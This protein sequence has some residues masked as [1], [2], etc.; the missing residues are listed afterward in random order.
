MEKLSDKKIWQLKKSALNKIAGWSEWRI[1]KLIAR[2]TKWSEKKILNQAL[3]EITWTETNEKI[4]DYHIFLAVECLAPWFWKR[5][6]DTIKQIPWVAEILPSNLRDNSLKLVYPNIVQN[7]NLFLENDDIGDNEINK[8]FQA[9]I[10]PFQQ[11]SEDLKQKNEELVKLNKTRT[12]NTLKTFLNKTRMK[13]DD[14]I[15]YISYNLN[16]LWLNTEWGIR[17]IANEYWYSSEQIDTIIQNFNEFKKEVEVK[18]NRRENLSSCIIFDH[19]LAGIAKKDFLVNKIMQNPLRQD[20]AKKCGYTDEQ[21]ATI[22]TNYQ[23][24]K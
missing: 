4:H 10:K 5:L 11:E 21:I 12:K 3:Q 18:T 13:D 2:V 22:E 8:L 7:I 14:W 15:P 6:I 20:I 16:E 23:K 9:C 19:L 1:Q 17:V 24:L